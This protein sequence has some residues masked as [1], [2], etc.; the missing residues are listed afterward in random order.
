MFSKV[1]KPSTDAE[2]A[3]LALRGEAIHQPHSSASANFMLPLPKGEGWG[4]RE[5]DIHQPEIYDETKPSGTNI[6]QL[7]QLLKKK[8]PGLR[9]NVE[10]FASDTR[11]SWPSGLPQIDDLLHG[12]LSKGALTEIIAE[13]RGAGS[14]LLACSLL[15]QAAQ[16]GQ[17]VAFVD[18]ADSLEVTQLEETVLSRLLW[19]RCRSAAEA[20]KATDLLLRDGNLPLVMLDLAINPEKQLRGIPTTT[21]YR[22]QRILEQIATVCVVFTPRAMV[23]PAHDRI[24]LR[25][26][27]SLNA[28]EQDHDKIL[29]ELKLEGA[30]AHRFGELEVNAS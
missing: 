14:A 20:L 5:H 29:A 4:E 15:R 16:A 24:F 10:D 11:N 18:G 17:I 12:G 23:S 30:E 19:V 27:F 28:L 7:R 9:T 21:W 25:S 2:V 8:F 6:I 22:L 26:R 13:H 3:R 1:T